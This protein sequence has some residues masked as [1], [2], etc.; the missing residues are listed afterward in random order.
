MSIRFDHIFTTKLES[1]T[2]L[3]RGSHDFFSDEEI[4]KLRKAEQTFDSSLRTIIFAVFENRYASLGGLSAIAGSMPRFIEEAG[5]RIAFF[6]PYHQNNKKIRWAQD[7]GRF[8][9]LFENIDFS[10]GGF[11]GVLSCLRDISAK[12]PSYYCAV[13]GHFLPKEDPYHYND[14]SLLSIDSLVFCAALPTA[15]N[16]LGLTK[17]LLIHAHDW[18]TAALALTSKIAVLNKQLSSIKTI[19]TLHNS[20]DAYLPK[21]MAERFF[22]KAT[23]ARTFLQ[24]FMPLLSG[25]LTTVSAPFAQELNHDPLQR[26]VFC[27]HLQSAFSKNPPIGIEN[28]AFTDHKPFFGPQAM[29]GAKR[30]SYEELLGEKEGLCR[31]AFQRLRG[32]VDPRALGAVNEGKDGVKTPLFLM[33]GR[34]DLMQKG[35]DAAIRA[36]ERLPRGRAKLFFCP[37]VAEGLSPDIKAFLDEAVLRCKGDFA[38][39]PFPLSSDDYFCL[40]AGAMFMLMPSF[41]EPFGS[42]TEAFLA[43][44]PVVARATG[45]LWAQV[46]PCNE[47]RIPAFYRG[48]LRYIGASQGGPTGILFREEYPDA[49]AEIEWKALLALPISQRIASPLYKSIVDSA[50]HALENAVECYLDPTRYGPMIFNSIESVKSFSWKHAVEAY[51]KVYDKTSSSII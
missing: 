7:H 46:A 6:S 37:N 5:E 26:G 14:P 20:Y 23:G 38:V 18:E 39:W 33:S 17:N 19:L 45:G 50:F 28:G 16:R 29:N 24:M 47:L 2:P 27:P 44:T 36:F 4:G 25:P 10:S 42:A 48:T 12:I 40:L 49:L 41:Y 31:R 9:T 13:D 32:G 30:G 34:L 43:G 51:R 35:F 1:W 8:E 11:S 21:T 22:G 15:L 3:G